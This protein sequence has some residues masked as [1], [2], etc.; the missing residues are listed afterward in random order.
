[1]N[2]AASHLHESMNRLAKSAVRCVRCVVGGRNRSSGD[3]LVAKRLY[4]VNPKVI[5]LNASRLNYD[6]QLDFSSW[7]AL[8]NNV[9]L[10]D[11]DRV[12][13]V[14]TVL[15]LVEQAEIVVTKEM[16]LP[17]TT[18][19]QFPPS[20]KLLCEAGTGYNN[21]PV[22]KARARNVAVCNTPTYSTDAVAHMAITYLLN[23][24]VS[25]FEQQHML[26]CENKRDNFTGPFTLPLHEVNGKILGLIGGAG[27]I[28]T[29]V[30]QI[31]LSLGMSI[32]ISSRRGSLPDNHVLHQH[33]KVT[34]TSD[35]NAVLQQSDYVSL[36]TPLNDETRG[37]FGRAQI[38]QMKPTAFLINTS[39]GAVCNEAELI[40]CMKEGRIAGAGL[41]VTT[42]EPP[43]MDSPLWNL[44]NVYLSPHTGWRRLET[45]QRLVEMTADN[46]R[47]YCNAS[48]P[49]DYI[50]V[51]N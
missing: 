27:R 49:A 5:F 51:V 41:D 50:N 33:L 21:L 12:D 7:H 32:I 39:R 29:T 44:P 30:A 38:E 19:V 17:A 18:F 22:Q 42:T 10:H 11:A 45:R 35:V 14:A 1:V 43:A 20:V 15:R 40:A 37:T 8:T 2:C 34:C 48:S 13:D 31:G 4:S 9:T 23:F 47:A 16:P 24:S 6:G 36:H 3:G 25:M 26:R 46:I 28:G